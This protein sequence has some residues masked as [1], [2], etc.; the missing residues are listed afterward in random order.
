MVIFCINPI[1]KCNTT[2]GQFRFQTSCEYLL[3]FRK[4]LL[5]VNTCK[6]KDL[7]LKKLLL[8]KGVNADLKCFYRWMKAKIKKVK[9][10]MFVSAIFSVTATSFLAKSEYWNRGRLLRLLKS[11][12]AFLIL[13]PLPSNE[14]RVKILTASIHWQCCGD[15]W[16]RSKQ[17]TRFWAMS[18]V[19]PHS[20]QCFIRRLVSFSYNNKEQFITSI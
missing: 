20:L 15:W 13:K 16:G 19:A 17:S 7:F 5:R 11:R 1:L 3:Q 14:E 4:R 8:H 12:R 9:R 2:P 18:T 10:P 6:F